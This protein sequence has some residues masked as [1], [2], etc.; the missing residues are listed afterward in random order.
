MERQRYITER[1]I[2]KLR[3]LFRKSVELCLT[4]FGGRAFNRFTA[5]TQQDPNGQWEERRINMA[6]FD[7][8]MVGFTKYERRQ[9][10]PRSDAVFEALVNLMAT[11]RE[12]IDA[13][14]LGTSQRDRMDTRIRLWFNELATVLGAPASEPRLF[15]PQ[16][17]RQFF[18][19]G[20]PPLCAICG[21][22]IRHIDDAAVDHI[23]PY[24]RSGPTDPSNARLTHRY[25]NSARGDR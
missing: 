1:D 3:E 22:Q 2:I 18:A 15:T 4:S 21:Q 6:L 24:S 14:T 17:K 10:V 19:Q 16:L 12:F 25:C 23:V 7:A 11:N 20:E 9:V 8:V 13:I 5:G